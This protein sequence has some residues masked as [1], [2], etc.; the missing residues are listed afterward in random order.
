MLRQALYRGLFALGAV[1]AVAYPGLDLATGRG[2]QWWHWINFEFPMLVMY[3]AGAY[4]FTRR[5]EHPVARRMLLAGC[6]FLVATTIGQLLSVIYVTSGPQTWFWLVNAFQQ[7]VEFAAGV[8]LVALFAVFPDGRYQRGYERRVVRVVALLPVLIPLLLLLTLSRIPINSNFVWAGPVITSPI[9]VGALSGLDRLATALYFGRLTLF[10]VAAVLL[11]LRYRR[12][13]IERR[14][15]ARWPLFSLIVVIP[16]GMGSLGYLFGL[17]GLIPAGS[18]IATAGAIFIP[19]LPAAEA[20]GFLRPHLLNLELVIRKS[21]AYFVLWLLIAFTYV[22]M[23]AA[24]GVAAA[25]RRY[26]VDAVVLLTIVATIA[27]QPLRA[28]LERLASRVVYRNR[29]SGYQAMS[30]LGSGLEAA[31]P[32][33]AAAMVA[34][35]VRQALD[36]RWA[37]VVIEGPNPILAVDML[38]ET[39]AADAALTAPLMYGEEVSGRVECGPRSEGRY[40]PRD[41]ELLFT[42]TRHAA[43]AIRNAALAAELADRLEQINVQAQEL[44][45]SRARI[46]QAEEAGRRRLERDIHDG[47]QQELVALLAKI[48]R[49]RNQLGRDPAAVGVLL[50]EL[51]EETKL[52]LNDLRDFA[53][54]I[55]PTVLSDR[56]LAEAIED[57]VSRLP[58]NVSLEVAEQVRNARFAQAVEGAAYFTV[59]E[60]LANAMKHASAR[61][62]VV[63]LGADGDDLVVEVSDDGA[64]FETRGVARSG[65][66]G[67]ADRIEALGG[68]F[69]VTSVPGRGTQLHATLPARTT[70]LV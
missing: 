31:A 52:A 40:R 4:V 42:L 32:E 3:I 49:A 18:G 62:L 5:P 34:A 44:H 56:G 9:H 16:F 11:I 30:K 6:S 10:V 19:T 61:R 36:A 41:T 33:R 66:S 17:S 39:P 51:Q 58:E 48:R 64:G 70:S 14:V 12:F 46:V 53:Q 22:A 54:G 15:Q 37:R 67:L 25:Q 50:E 68:H 43:L 28:G 60:G 8:A 20:I 59:C 69:Q 27:F 55:H 21:V 57:R 38:T 24:V 63:R 2:P 26:E 45:A 7:A 23:A 1:A 65:L 13:D 47:V 35:I 29:L